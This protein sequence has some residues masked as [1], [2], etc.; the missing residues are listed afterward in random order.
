MV[1][2]ANKD[3]I[4][5]L[6]TASTDGITDGVDHIHSGVIKALEAAARGNYILDYNTASF[7]QVTG[8]TRTSFGFSAAINYM[9]DGVVTSADP[10]S[11]EL[12]TSPHATLTRYDL[13]VIATGGALAC[14]TG[15]E[16]AIPTVSALSIGDIPVALVKVE[17][18]TGLNIVSRD[19]QLYGYNKETN[20]V[21]IAYSTGSTYTET[22]SIIGGA[23]RTTFHNKIADA[24]IRFI[25]ADN[26]ADEKFEIMTDDGADGELTPI[27]TVFSVDGLGATTIAN[28]LS[29]T[30]GD[31]TL[32]DDVNNADVSLKM[33]TSATEALSIEVLNGGSDKTNVE[34]KIMTTTASGTANHG[35]ISVYIDEVEI[36]DID[37]GGID[38]ASG[39]TFAING[40]DIVSSP[41]TAVNN[42]TANELVT[43]GATTTELDA[44]ANLTFDGSTLAVTG[45]VTA[46]TTATA[47]VGLSTGGT[48]STSYEVCA[49]PPAGGTPQVPVPTMAKHVIY[50]HDHSGGGN[51]WALPNAISGN[52]Y[53]IKNIFPTPIV[54][55]MTGGETV[56]L[57]I[58]AG[59]GGTVPC[60]NALNTITLTYNQSVTLQGTNDTITP[61]QTGWLVIGT[62]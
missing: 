30:A 4:T 6:T 18:G 1:N 14:R 45:A 46:T 26:T 8:S 56:D 21:S 58:H 55:T 52:I 31:L 9:R 33:G 54:I 19:I 41:I 29:I 3:Y 51:T 47:T 7:Q 39:K 59:N 43:I 25:L 24:D 35:K 32:Y 48:F 60:V 53:H 44:E 36:L 15:T 10:A 2:Y 23:D 61:L 34:T 27:S 22:M 40:T 11:V 38:L 5:S 37:D 62:A 16:N 13:I 28:S 50:S 20:A 42:A 57:G 17:A 49:N 12:A